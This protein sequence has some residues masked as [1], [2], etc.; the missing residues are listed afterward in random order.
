MDKIWIVSENSSGYPA[1]AALASSLGASAQAVWIGNREGAD[2][3]SASSV[4]QV[5]WADVPEGA[6]YENGSA[7]VLAAFRE[8][9]PDA[10]LAATSKRTR[11]LAAQ[12]AAAAGTRVVN[13]AT[14]VTIDEGGSPCAEHMVYGGNA[15][16]TEQV[17]DGCAIILVSTSLLAAQDVRKPGENAPI[18]ELAPS[19][20]P[21]IAL[22][23]RSHRE[24]EQVNLSA[25]R[26]VISVGRGLARE[27][28]LQLAR[29]LAAAV[30]AELG[31]TRPIAEGEGWM[32][33]ERY[34]GVSG[35]MLKP[36]LFIALGVS[37]QV[38]HM[39]GVTGA[40]TIIAINKDKNA[41]VFRYA[42]YGIVGDLYEVVP[43]LVEL[44]K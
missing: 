9:A 20:A 40:R 17:T 8:S 36:E 29:E 28:D 21:G 31:C 43:Q 23:D 14:S 4:E 6:L 30:N 7:A 41:P 38:Q 25:A 3:V 33:R 37:G 11:L 32:S 18:V 26:N 13:D 39:V 42:D 16:R 15:Y 24:V 35:A 12:L 27:E 34:I 22:V 19:R 2:T 5:L 10:V 1:L 44:L